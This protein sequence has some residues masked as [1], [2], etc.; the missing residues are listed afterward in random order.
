M[1][2]PKIKRSIDC[3]PNFTS[4]KPTGIRGM[5]LPTMDLALDEFE[6][7]RLADA[8]GLDH[9]ESAEQMNISRSTFSRL[10]EKARHKVAIFLVEGRR[11]QIEGGDIHFQKN[12]FRCHGCRHVFR[13]AFDEDM[14]RCTECGSTDLV[15]LAEE[16]GH[17]RCCQ[18]HHRRN[19]R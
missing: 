5:Q 14:N 11:L 19:E 2:R 1:T 18:R 8:M 16:F 7:I 12:L 15:D 9:A 17:G 13:A 4:F 10:V 6:A 3:P